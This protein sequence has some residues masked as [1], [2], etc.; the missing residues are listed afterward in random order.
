MSVAIVLDHLDSVEIVHARPF[1]RG[2]RE[3]K[4]GGMNDVDLNPKAS[5]EAKHSACVEGD[6]GL[7][8]GEREWQ[9]QN[10][11]RTLVEVKRV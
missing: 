9:W 5:A 8:E 7:V 1:E 4:S 10:R 3:G 6:V 11:G 2:A